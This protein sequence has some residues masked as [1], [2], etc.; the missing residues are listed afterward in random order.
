[1][2]SGMWT[3]E[4]YEKSWHFKETKVDFYDMKGVVEVV[5]AGLNISGVRFSPL[6]GASAPYMK[7][8]HAALVRADDEI[9]GT[10]GELSRRVLSNF[11][12]KN[13]VYCFDLNFDLLTGRVSEE[14]QAKPLSRFPATFRDIALILD[15]K[16]GSQDVLD[17]IAGLGQELIEEVDVFDIYRGSPVPAGKKSVALRFTYRSFERNLTDEEVNTIHEGV[18]R[19]LLKQFK[20]QLP[21]G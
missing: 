8:G 15:D 5:C 18:T 9:L 11:G 21:A 19:K 17:F 16:L 20:A 7:R 14:K 13:P 10:V 2:A 12:L 6:T 3:G 1:M 4:R